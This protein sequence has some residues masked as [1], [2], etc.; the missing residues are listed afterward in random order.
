M[1]EPDVAASN[2]VKLV[3]AFTILQI[4]ILASEQYPKGLGH[5][6]PELKQELPNA[7]V[8]EKIHFSCC[9]AQ[10]IWEAIESH[11]RKQIL[12]VGV[13]SHV[14][15]L[16][17]VLDLLHAGYQVHVPFDA[18]AS[19]NPANKENALQRMRGAGA[20]ITNVESA[21]FELMARAGTDDFKQI[22]KL[23]I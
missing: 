15:V 20:V 21:L 12:V 3:K 22:Q 4:P 5:T 9:G 10:E 16:Q 1:F 14:C 6:L 13:E 17:T 7:E 19:R 2:V 23:I 11:K 18:V 8:I